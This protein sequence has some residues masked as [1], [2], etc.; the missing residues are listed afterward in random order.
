MTFPLVNGRVPWRIIAGFRNCHRNANEISKNAITAGENF[1]L[2]SR[3]VF[4]RIIAA[5]VE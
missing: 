4:A 3:T 1:R 2:K 5:I